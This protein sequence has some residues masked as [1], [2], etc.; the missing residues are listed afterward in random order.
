MALMRRKAGHSRIVFGTGFATAFA[1]TVYAR[2]ASHRCA[3]TVA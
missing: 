1:Q 3:K 2:P